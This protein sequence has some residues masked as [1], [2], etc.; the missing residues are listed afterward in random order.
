MKQGDWPATGGI[1][2]VQGEG[3][4]NANDVYY[5]S[6]GT[7][8][9][10]KLFAESLMKLD[11]TSARKRRSHRMENIDAFAIPG[12]REPVS[13][14]THL[15]AVPVFAVLGGLLVWRGRGNRCRM[16]SLAILAVSTVF[17][18]TMS[19]LYHLLGAGT[20]R[21]MMRQLDVAGV[22]I[23]IAGTVT[24]VHTILFR[25]FDRWAPLLLVWSAAA[26]GI[27]LRT[28][29]PQSL[30]PGFGNALFL[31]MGWG[32]IIS[33]V[34]LWRRYGFAFVRPVLLGGMAYT[35][36]VTVLDMKWP[37]LLPGIVG[38]HEL[39]HVAVLAGLGLHWKFVFQ[40]A[41][42]PPDGAG[43]LK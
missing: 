18:L 19:A 23:L 27:T 25:G 10:G 16:I 37:I 3:D 24:P 28:M 17:L 40:F 7:L 26:A 12:F 43:K 35:V 15:L 9:V 13:C 39:W 8:I 22:F 34:R 6:R 29:Y 38:A 14:F 21:D 33:C 20:S 30:P 42:G 1:L 36:G 41:A 4:A 2:W 32:G 11:L 5:D 31:L